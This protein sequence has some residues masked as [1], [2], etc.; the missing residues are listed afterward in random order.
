MSTI[1]HTRSSAPTRKPPTKPATQSNHA[2]PAQQAHKTETTTFTP[3]AKELQKKSEGLQHKAHITHAT[4]EM[5]ENGHH[6]AHN[7]THALKDNFGGGHA[8][9]AH[10]APAVKPG[11][12]GMK[13]TPLADQLGKLKSSAPSAPAP[14]PSAAPATQGPLASKLGPGTAGDMS[15]IR[16]APSL[17]TGEAPHAPGVS[18]LTKGIAGLG[19]ASGAL[20]TVNEMNNFAHATTEKDKNYHAAGVASNYSNFSSGVLSMAGRT[21]AGPLAASIGTGLDGGRDIYMGQ[22]NHDDKQVRVGGAKCVG[23]GLMGAS[24]LCGPAAPFVFA[25][26]VGVTT[27]AWLASDDGQHTMQDV[28]RFFTGGKAEAHH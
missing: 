28:G 13:A 18:G 24:V 2:K 22:Q 5:L 9:E 27:G 25:A 1:S 6:A 20:G 4:S 21:V 3:E 17:T 12:L 23:A 10:A 26:G 15:L 14:R 19:A 7:L 8:S 11:N 16:R